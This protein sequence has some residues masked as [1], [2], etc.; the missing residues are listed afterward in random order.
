MEQSSTTKTEALAIGGGVQAKCGK[1]KGETKHTI[2]A[3]VDEAPS[4]VRCTIC[5]ADH[6]YRKPTKPRTPKAPKAPKED[7]DVALWA[8]LSPKWDADKAVAYDMKKTYEKGD[9]IKHK[10][11]GIGQV[12]QLLAANKMSVL[13]EV[14][15]K[16]MVCSQ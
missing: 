2:L 12:Q 1:C 5:E 15:I 14:G 4:K 10:T 6:K 11:Y 9:I 3:L 7:P 8:K 16:L 13:F